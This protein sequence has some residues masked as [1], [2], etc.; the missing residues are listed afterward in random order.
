MA[1]L[2]DLLSYRNPRDT[3]IARLGLISPSPA[4]SKALAQAADYPETVA[5]TAMLAS[6]YW[7]AIALS[8][9]PAGNQRFHCE[10]R[11]RVA[12]GHH[13]PRFL[14]WL[15]RDLEWH[16]DRPLRITAPACRFSPALPAHR[17]GGSI[18]VGQAS[19]STPTQT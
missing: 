12:P 13:D 11:Q 3:R 9:T 2:S 10:F 4:A 16:P 7:H 5:F 8:R 14:F 18:V 1:S 19:L 6:P 15:R 17:D